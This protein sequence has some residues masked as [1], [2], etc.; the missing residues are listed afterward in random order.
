M[1]EEKKFSKLEEFEKSDYIEIEV[2]EDIMNSHK[3]DSEKSEDN[4]K[5]SDDKNVEK[6][7]DSKNNKDESKKKTDESKDTSDVSKK[8]SDEL[9]KKSDTSKKESDTSKEKSDNKSADKNGASD[10]QSD[11]KK[12]EAG[13]TDNKKEE[14]GKAE[15]KEADNKTDDKKTK[16]DK[17][18]ADKKQDSDNKDNSKAISQSKRLAD[19]KAANEIK[20]NKDE[21]KNVTNDKPKKKKW[22]VVVLCVT[23]FLFLAVY[24]TGFWYFSSNF[25]PDVAING[26][27]VSNMDEVTAKNTLDNFYSAYALTLH[28]VDNK[29]VT[30]QGKD[31][32]MVI[33]LKENVSR[34]FNEQKPYLWFVEIFNHQDFQIEADATWNQ[35]KLDDIYK[36]M[37]ILISEDIVDPVD[38]Y[39]GLDGNHYAIID[40]VMGN[41]LDEEIFKKKVTEKLQLIYPTMDL[42]EEDCY[43]KPVVYKDSQPLVDELNKLGDFVNSVITLKL[44]D[45]EIEPSMDLLNEVLDLQGSN[46]TVSETKVKNYVKKLADQYDTLGTKR[47]FKTSWGNQYV[48]IEGKTIGYVMD[49]EKTAQALLNALNQKK[50]ATVE[51]L[52]VQKGISLVGENDIGD[53][54]IECNLT[55][56]K[57]VAYKNGRKLAESDCVS[58]CISQGHGTCL[59]MYVIQGKQSPSVLRGDLE[60]RTTTVVAFDEAG[61][62]YETTQTTMVPSYESHVTY[63]MPFNGGYGLHDAD[64]WRSSYG[65]EIFL[66]SGSHGCVNLPRSFAKTLY[67]NFDIGTPV[68]V[69]YEDNDDRVKR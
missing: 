10:N 50:P 5:K 60:P 13:K 52:F 64:G 31:I 7:D 43:C 62:P 49:Q 23:L 33:T 39:I 11:D 17:K 18:T 24:F 29:D 68:L 46:A 15:K 57:V 36:N 3:T 61:N 8:E 45:L 42:K 59:G 38:A 58:G 44:D 37:D 6:K 26:N 32:D 9:K 19:A 25:Y 55:K 63:W 1:S 56:Q 65:G 14:S 35:E 40:E 66:Y 47:N 2:S 69:Y 48:Q 54:Y 28:T 4:I 20:E 41:R 27:N 51:A 22:P 30:I 34:C 12:K 21:E 53:T 16:T 67:E